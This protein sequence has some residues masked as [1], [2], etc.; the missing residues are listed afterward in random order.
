M[1]TCVCACVRPYVSGYVYVFV[2]MF[3]TKY[4]VMNE[5]DVYKRSETIK[6]LITNDKV[7]R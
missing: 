7:V 4:F 5:D 2:C 1:Y 3:I 6:D